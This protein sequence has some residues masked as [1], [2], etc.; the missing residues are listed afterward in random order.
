[1]GKTWTEKE[2]EICCKVAVDTYVIE[3]KRIHVNECANIIHSCEGIE[4]NKNIVVVR[5]QNIKALLDEMNV[6]NTLDVSPLSHAG[7]QTRAC[8]VAYLEECGVKK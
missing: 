8:L 5:L 2:D 7:K 1:M 4:H 3:R 6:P